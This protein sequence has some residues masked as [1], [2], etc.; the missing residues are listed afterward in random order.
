MLVGGRRRTAG[1]DE[2]RQPQRQQLHH[3]IRNRER[4]AAVAARQVRE[5]PATVRAAGDVLDHD[6]TSVPSSISTPPSSSTVGRST[7][8]SMCTEERFTPPIPT[9]VPNARW[10]VPSAFSS[11]STLP[12]SRAAG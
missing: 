11:S 9:L 1:G 12:V 8:P 2:V 6:W 10:I 4:A 5:R 3:P 7:S